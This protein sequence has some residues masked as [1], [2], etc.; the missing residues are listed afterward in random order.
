MRIIAVLILIATGAVLHAQVEMSDGFLITGD[1]KGL[2][3]SQL[4]VLKFV[5]GG[6]E[7][8]SIFVVDGEFE[9]SGRVEEPYFIQLL[10]KDG[11]ETNGKLTEFMIENS[12]ISIKGNSIEYD[13]V[14]V[15]GSKSD[16]ILKEYL[17]KDEMLGAKWNELKVEYDEYV[18]SGDTIKRKEVAKELNYILQE[19]RVGLLREYVLNNSNSTVGALLPS[20]CTIS[21]ALTKVDYAEFYQSLSEE[22]KQSGYGQEL[23][24][25]SRE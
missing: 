7:V 16:E 14:K 19:E 8:D 9:Y 6:L 18:A 15:D 22:V 17:K 12:E 13:S 24:E 21:G 23:L 10:I 2:D 1:V 25:R 20:F 4:L 11:E 3:S 5:N